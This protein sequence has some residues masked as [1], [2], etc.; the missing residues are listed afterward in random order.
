[1][2]LDQVAVKK[3]LDEPRAA[4]A[5][6]EPVAGRIEG[7]RALTGDALYAAA[8]LRQAIVDQGQDYVVKLKKNWPQLHRD[9]RCS[10]PNP[11]RRVIAQCVKAT[12][13]GSSGRSGCR[14]NWR[15]MPH[16]RG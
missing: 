16:S 13:A 5:W 7:L 2:A 4:Q 1:M 14:R 6:S 11:A 10:F 12:L 8:D 3:H 15:L 9:V